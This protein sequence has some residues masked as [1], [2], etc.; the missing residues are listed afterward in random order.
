MTCSLTL[1]HHGSSTGVLYFW[2]T[3]ALLLGKQVA[4]VV[5][6]PWLKQS[7]SK[8]ATMHC[9]PCFG[10]LHKTVLSWDHSFTIIISCFWDEI[11]TRRSLQWYS[12]SYI[13]QSTSQSNDIS[14]KKHSIKENILHI[15][16]NLIRAFFMYCPLIY[17]SLF[18]TSLKTESWV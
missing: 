4:A 13:Y 3:K 2:Y 17:L 14:R 1:R 10:L 16:K 7:H 15:S 18:Y 5:I 9:H 6:R 12:L 11:F 8:L